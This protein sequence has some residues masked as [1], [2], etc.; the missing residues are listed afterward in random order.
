[1]SASSRRP[2]GAPAPEDPLTELVHAIH[3]LMGRPATREERRRF[4]R[5]LDLLLQWNRTQRLTALRSE[6]DIARHLFRDS[7][8]FLPQLPG[9]PLALVD[10]GAGAGI[11]G[12]PLRIVEPG[13]SLTMVESKR[14]RVSFLSTLKREL[15]LDDIRILEGRAEDL[16]VQLPELIGAFDSAV[17]RAVGPLKALIPTVLG[18]LKPGGLLIVSGPPQGTP[19]PAIPSE[20]KGRWETTDFPTLGLSRVFLKV[21]KEA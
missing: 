10:I 17:L 2:R 4:T 5:Y 21:S 18:Y 6:A 12:V 3:L 14:K 7:L 11:P 8:L 15:G 1:M 20:L 16:I 13:V 9:R 19:L